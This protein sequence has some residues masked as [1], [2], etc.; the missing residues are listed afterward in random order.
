MYRVISFFVIQAPYF[1]LIIT[2]KPFTD[3]VNNIVEIVNEILLTG[4]LSMLLYYNQSSR[5]DNRI[6]EVFVY[7]ILSNSVLVSIIFLISMLLILISKCAKKKKSKNR[8]LDLP[9]NETLQAVKT[10]NNM[11]ATFVRFQ[12][13]RSNAS[14][15]NAISFEQT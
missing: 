2:I 6:E 12:Q 15:I 10:C 1:V 11:D 13:Y 14:N 9:N 7:F 3:I 4:L 8:V 5:W